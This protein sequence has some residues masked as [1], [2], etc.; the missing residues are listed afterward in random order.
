[1]D[2]ELIAE[3]LLQLEK[4]NPTEAPATSPLLNGKWKFLYAGG[5]TPGLVSLVTL[6][7]LASLAPKSP[8]GASLVDVGEATVTISRN[9][10]RVEASLRVRVLSVENTLKL[11]TTLEAKT[12]SILTESYKEV[13]SELFG[14]HAAASPGVPSHRSPSRVRRLT[15][16]RPPA[17]PFRTPP[18]RPQAAAAV[19]GELHAL[20]DR[21]VRRR[22]PAHRALARR[23][24]GCA[25]AHGQGVEPPSGKR[26]RRRL[27]GDLL[28]GAK[29]SA[30]MRAR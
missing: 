5:R 27:G 4:L 8:S 26:G 14:T 15:S 13:E 11:F 23:R 29:E 3:L 12:G 18:C 10:P 25:D 30:V 21:H 22:G 16:V 7:R 24:A 2:R 17:L 6:L 28:S 9:Q 1:V 20:A 19:A